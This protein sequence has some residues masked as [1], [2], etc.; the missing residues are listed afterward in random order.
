VIQ[1]YIH[2]YVYG[3]SNTQGQR[4]T[5]GEGSRLIGSRNGFSFKLELSP[6]FISSSLPSYFL[7]KNSI[8]FHLLIIK[9]SD[10]T[11][12]IIKLQIKFTSTHLC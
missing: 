7:Y 11:N 8:G 6:F 2:T 1:I 5:V 10:P 4:E 9:K 12:A 3:C